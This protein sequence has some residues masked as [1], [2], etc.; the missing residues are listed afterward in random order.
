M[1]NKTLA[2]ALP[3]II[4]ISVL[5]LTSVMAPLVSYMVAKNVNNTATVNTRS[6]VSIDKTKT[7]GLIDTYT[8]TYSDETTSSF[9]V[10]NGASGTEGIQGLP[11]QDGHTPTITIDASTGNWIID[12]V[13]S[14]FLARG[15]QGLPGQDGEKPQLHLQLLQQVR[16]QPL[17]EI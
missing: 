13:D 3:I 7:E 1:K 16:W 17:L 12:G 5:V 9:F 10:V 6:I 2:K 4:A 14:G 11:G 15:P 8:I